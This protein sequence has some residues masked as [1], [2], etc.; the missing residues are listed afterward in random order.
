MAARTVLGQALDPDDGLDDGA[1]PLHQDFAPRPAR[2]GRQLVEPRHRVEVELLR[3]RDGGRGTDQVRQPQ[4]LVGHLDLP[5]GRWKR[6]P[7]VGAGQRAEHDQA[8]AKD[9]EELEVTIECLDQ[10]DEEVVGIH[11]EN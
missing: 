1:A 5:N 6:R 9:G 2:T 4:V 7:L 10:L 8:V 3:H 11:C